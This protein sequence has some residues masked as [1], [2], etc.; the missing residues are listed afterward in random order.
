LGPGS[1]WT[2]ALFAVCLGIGNGIMTI[3]RAAAVAEL[4]SRVGFGA[5]NGAI[6]APVAA[7]RAL[8]PSLASAIWVATGGYVPV[9]WILTGVFLFALLAFVTAVKAR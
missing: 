2:I 7:G 6:N 3:V 8:G 4:I 5:I 1:F 9:L